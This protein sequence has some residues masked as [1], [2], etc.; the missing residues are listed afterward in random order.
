M[1]DPDPTPTCVS[2]VPIFADLPPDEQ[3]LVAELTHPVQLSAGE[4]VHAPTDADTRL[5]IVHSGRVKVFRYKS[6][7]AEQILRV[8][9]PG[10][11]VGES[12]V[13]TGRPPTT[14]ATAVDN[15]TR[16]CTFLG[17]DLRKLI[18]QRPQIGIRMMATLAGR[19]EDA[20]RRLISLGSE[21]VAVRLADYLLGL[22][23]SIIDGGPSVL[24]PLAKKDIASLL[25]TTP[26]SISRALRSL[27]AQAVIRVEGSTVSILDAE[28]LQS[29][30]R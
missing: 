15:E 17:S 20:E 14:W 11:F 7:G 30:V 22:P 1:R 12:S 19:L 25:D 3:L 6:D 5:S 18:S 9:R 29:M 24:L 4:K 13:V 10:D 23:V 2:R 8:L 21:G 27:A 26:E 16:L 28:T